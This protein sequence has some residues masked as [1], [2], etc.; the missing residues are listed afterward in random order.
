MTND[1]VMSTVRPPG[2][3]LTLRAICAISKCSESTM[4][5]LLKAG[6]GPPL[7]KRPG[8]NRF[9]GYE[10]VR[11]STGWNPIAMPASGLR[12]AAVALYRPPQHAR[13]ENSTFIKRKSSWPLRPP[14][15]AL[16][17]AGADAS[18]AAP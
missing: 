2:A 17:R 8:S 7:F 11:S 3:L 6:L 9:L 12:V 4:R 18:S 13:R 1:E 14:G 5:G 16:R 10:G 15:R